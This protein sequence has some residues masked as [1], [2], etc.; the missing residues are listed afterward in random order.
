MYENGNIDSLEFRVLL[1]RS[2]FFERKLSDTIYNNNKK[3]YCEIF[4]NLGSIISSL[5][6][7]LKELGHDLPSR[8]EFCYL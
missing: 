4:D 6:P 2:F 7:F 8:K 5:V 1:L 3:L